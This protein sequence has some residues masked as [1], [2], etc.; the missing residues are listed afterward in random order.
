MKKKQL[1]LS[2]VMQ[3]KEE[4]AACRNLKNQDAKIESCFHENGIAFNT[5]T[6]SSFALMIEESMKFIRQYPL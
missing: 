2:K 1:A 4:A 6:S 3:G 5:T